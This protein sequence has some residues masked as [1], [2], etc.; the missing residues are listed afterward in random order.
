VSNVCAAISKFARNIG[1]VA[2]LF[3]S[4]HKLASSPLP[5]LP[6][7]KNCPESWNAMRSQSPA[8]P[9]FAELERLASPTGAPL[10]VVS[11]IQF[12]APF[13]FHSHR[14]EEASRGLY[15]HAGS[16]SS[17][18]VVWMSVSKSLQS[19]QYLYFPKATVSSPSIVG[20][21]IARPVA[22]SNR[23]LSGRPP[24]G[25]FNHCPSSHFGRSAELSGGGTFRAGAPPPVASEAT[26]AASGAASRYSFH[27]HAVPACRAGNGK[28]G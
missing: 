23:R 16:L 8:A 28:K 25:F 27:K 19:G 10:N 9:L 11:T 3:T 26:A 5:C 21:A 18:H 6:S 2:S 12:V 22:L 17:A 13:A 7:R 14:I 4:Y 24:S 20:S 1:D 15:G